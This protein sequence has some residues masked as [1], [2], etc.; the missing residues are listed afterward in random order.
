MHVF[1]TVEMYINLV[2]CFALT[3]GLVVACSL[4]NSTDGQMGLTIK[5]QFIIHF[6]ASASLVESRTVDG[7][8]VIASGELL[9]N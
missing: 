1:T 2:E 7:A 4:F 9:F 3:M 6:S 8:E 5:S